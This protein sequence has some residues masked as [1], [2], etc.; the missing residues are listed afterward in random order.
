MIVTQLPVGRQQL[1]ASCRRFDCSI[2]RDVAGMARSTV[3]VS[4]K[5]SNG[6]EI[7]RRFKLATAAGILAATGF[8][9]LVVAPPANASVRYTVTWNAVA[10]RTGPGTG[11]SLVTRVNAGTPI[12]IAC[13]VQN[14]TNVGGNATWDQ[15]TSGVWL[16]DYYTNTPSFNSYISGVRDCF[17]SPTSR[18]TKAIGWARG[19]L[20]HR[21]D[22]WGR[23]TV[24]WCARWS[25]GAYGR[26]NAGYG[27]AWNMFLDFNAKHM[28]HSGT[29]PA[30]A[31]VFFRT[32]S[33][34]GWAGHVAIADG[35]G[36]MITTTSTYI[37]Q[38]P[39]SYAGAPYLGWS[40]AP[41]GWTR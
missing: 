34:N 24:N 10:E 22:D 21:T 28:I 39:L 38:R 9:G 27:T 5:L 12:D 23:P 16:S 19:Q 8:A 26:M 13:Q 4:D 15:L 25:V 31:F 7:M 2:W 6:V 32:A 20:G 11:Y 14:G 36:G 40:Y 17:T 3:V 33:V 1:R 41:A 29:A 18:E 37:Q 35:Q 30:G